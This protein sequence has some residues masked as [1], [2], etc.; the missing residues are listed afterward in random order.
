ME[1][2]HEDPAA[3]NSWYARVHVDGQCRLENLGYNGGKRQRAACAMSILG[4]QEYEFSCYARMRNYGAYSSQ[5][6]K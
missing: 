3:E 6:K 2:L 4:G 5:C 1:S